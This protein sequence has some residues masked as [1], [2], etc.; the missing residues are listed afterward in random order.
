MHEILTLETPFLES[1]SDLYS[2]MCSNLGLSERQTDMVMLSS[3]CAGHTDFPVEVLQ[4][5]GVDKYEVDFV[6]KLLIPDPRLRMSA[7]HAL[8]SAWLVGSELAMVLQSCHE[9]LIQFV[10][11]EKPG[12]T[13]FFVSNLDETL[14][15]YSYKAGA[16]AMKLLG[17]G[18]PKGIA[19]DLGVLTLYDLVLL[20][21]K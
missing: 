15:P 14:L 7:R 3:F 6:R 21:G 20:I 12:L 19:C 8:R 16:L 17:M 18:C 1:G 5:S 11:K 4:K 10:A 2:T 13:A 9:R